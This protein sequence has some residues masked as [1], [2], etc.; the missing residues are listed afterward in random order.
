[1]RSDGVFCVR[2]KGFKLRSIMMRKLITALSV[3]AVTAA[4][5]A[6]PTF[7]SAQEGQYTTGY[8][9]PVAGVAVGSAVGFG[10]YNGWYGANAALGST[11]LPTTAAGAATV[12]GIA[13]VGTVALIDAAFQPCRGFHALFGANKTACVNGEYVGDAPRP[14]RLR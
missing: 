1:M 13:G 9:G 6:M 7:A 2:V 5:V 14:R 10:L 3:A 4:A 8:A 12:G 11:L